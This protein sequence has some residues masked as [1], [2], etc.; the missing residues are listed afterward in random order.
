MRVV[1]GCRSFGSGAPR[2][3][4]H[5]GGGEAPAGSASARTRS[6]LSRESCAERTTQ[7]RVC[8]RLYAKERGPPSAMVGMSSIVKHIMSFM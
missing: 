3:W 8:A 7:K 5:G 4:K 2:Q 1:S 6:S